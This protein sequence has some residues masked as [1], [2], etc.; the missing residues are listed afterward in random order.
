MNKAETLNQQLYD[1]MQGEYNDFIEDLKKKTPDEIIGFSYE[2][3]F[4]EDILMCFE[5]A[6]A[7]LTA[8]EANALLKQKKPL[9]FLYNAWLDYD[10]SY[11]DMLRDSN[12]D[13]A[14]NEAARLHEQHKANKEAR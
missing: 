3:V 12:K 9:E 4:K 5:Y 14:S 7:T 13:C 1:K 8:N 10:C 11:M 6:E 2:K